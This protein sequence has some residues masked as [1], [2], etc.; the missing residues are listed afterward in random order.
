[1]KN[2]WVTAIIVAIIVGAIAFYGGMQYQKSQRGSSRFGGAGGFASRYGAGTSGSTPI[3]GKIVQ[4]GNNS[5][6]V[7]LSDGSS[8][9]VLLNGSTTIM[10]STSAP[11]GAL[12]TGKQVLIFGSTNSDGSVTAQNVSVNPQGMFRGGNGGGNAPSQ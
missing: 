6:T 7:Q 9:I 2:V 10:Q 3:R 11:Q 8:K 12:S 1:M 5:I 4:S